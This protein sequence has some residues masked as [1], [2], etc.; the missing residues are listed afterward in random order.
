MTVPTNCLESSA[1]AW[2]ISS[3][4][5][6]QIAV[7]LK[8]KPSFPVIFATEPS[9]AMFPYKVCK[10]PVFL[11]GS[12]KGTIT[13]CPSFKSGQASKFS[14]NV[15]PV[16]VMQDPSI[17][18]FAMRY[19]NTAGVP[20]T[21]CTSSMTYFPLGFKSAMNGVL[22]L[23]AWKSSKVKLIP[24]AC[25]IAIKCNTA[26]VLPPRAITI[27]IAFSKAARVM[28]SLGFKSISNMCLIAFPAKKHSSV[29]NGSSAGIELE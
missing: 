7:P 27:V 19:F 1:N 10:C 14:A 2:S 25:A 5:S 16:T 3:S 13:S 4:E 20:P 11:I 26:F 22:S 18:P 8:Y 21:L 29:F 17:K 12:S 6:K 24:H 28:M 23:T 15:L 9:G